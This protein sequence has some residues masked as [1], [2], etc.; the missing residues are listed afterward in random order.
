MNTCF[1][2]FTLSLYLTER[3][4]LILHYEVQE[5]KQDV[6][7]DEGNEEI[8]L[9]FAVRGLHVYRR[10]VWI[11][12]VGQLLSD[13]SEDGNAEDRFAEIYPL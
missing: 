4:A 6:A 7:M 10:V 11:P 3:G 5:R 1:V 12:R 13:E 2:E 8:A 9:P